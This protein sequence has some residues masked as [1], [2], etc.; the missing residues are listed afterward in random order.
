ME[1]RV[2]SINENG[3]SMADSIWLASRSFRLWLIQSKE[4]PRW[5]Q[6]TKFPA[7]I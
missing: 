7:H 5:S 1:S 3:E 2:K 6:L 4:N